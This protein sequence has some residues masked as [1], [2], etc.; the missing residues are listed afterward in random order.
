MAR[1][2][3]EGPE[4]YPYRISDV[5]AKSGVSRQAIHYYV[6]EGLLSPP[7]KTSKNFGWYSDQHLKTLALIQKLQHERFLPL[8]AIKSLLKGSKEFE[9]SDS[10]FDILA[11]I[12]ERLGRGKGNLSVQQSPA[13]LANEMGLSTS[14]QKQLRDFLFLAKTGVA[15]VSDVEITRLWIQMRDAGLTLDRGFGP[16]DLR[17]IYELVDQAVDKEVGMLRDRMHEL[18]LNEVGNLVDVVIPAINTIFNIVHQRRIR[19]Y[20][21]AYLDTANRPNGPLDT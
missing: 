4:G 5:M 1:K 8:K 2:K 15:T 20:I 6:K 21:D 16:K 17:Y 10:Q 7:F 11:G 3:V 19:A 13:E 9:F 12:R 14:E 18:S